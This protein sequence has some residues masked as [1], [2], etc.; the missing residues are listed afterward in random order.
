MIAKQR[1]PKECHI[2]DGVMWDGTISDVTKELLLA[3]TECG[4]HT[5]GWIN[6]RKT[7]LLVVQ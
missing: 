7:L 3:V 4:H 2:E 5:R 1:H 6:V